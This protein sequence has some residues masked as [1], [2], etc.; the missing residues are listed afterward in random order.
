M[1]TSRATLAHRQ[2]VKNQLQHSPLPSGR[3]QHRSPSSRHRENILAGNLAH[4]SF[5]PLPNTELYM[6]TSFAATPRCRALHSCA[7]TFRR[8]RNNGGQNKMGTLSA[9]SFSHKR[10]TLDVLVKNTM[11]V[12]LRR[13]HAFRSAS[14][15]ARHKQQ[16]PPPPINYRVF[17]HCTPGNFLSVYFYEVARPRR[18]VLRGF[19]SS[20][21]LFL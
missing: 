11:F 19:S 6:H 1:G 8:I 4:M 13:A 2:V 18:F 15:F 10:I 14:S 21:R 16:S 9:C 7:Q 12:Y 17:F 3:E 20:G 5:H